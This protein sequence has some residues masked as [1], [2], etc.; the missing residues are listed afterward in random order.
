MS[1]SFQK[2]LI[3]QPR[4]GYCTQKFIKKSWCISKGY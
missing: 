2:K 4:W 1:I 3:C